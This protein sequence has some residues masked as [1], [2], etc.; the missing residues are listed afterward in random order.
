MNQETENA[1]FLC[2]ICVLMVVDAL[3]TL[4]SIFNKGLNKTTKVLPIKRTQSQLAKMLKKDLVEL[5]IQYQ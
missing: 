4:L 3:V 1:I 2:I 5:V